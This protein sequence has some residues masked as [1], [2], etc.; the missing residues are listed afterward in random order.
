VGVDRHRHGNGFRQYKAILRAVPAKTIPEFIAYAKANP[1]KINYG[2]A[3]TFIP[4]R[5]TAPVDKPFPSSCG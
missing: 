2:S 1:G 3:G 4:A 5:W